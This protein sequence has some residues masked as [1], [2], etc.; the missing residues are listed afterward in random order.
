MIEPRTLSQLLTDDSLEPVQRAIVQTLSALLPDVRVV[1]HP[2]RVD[3]SE[4]LAKSVATAPGIGIG[5]SRVRRAMHVDGSF[6][7]LV[8]WVAYIVTEAKLVSGK[9]VEK[10]AIGLAIGGQVLRVL[11]D[12]E[13]CFWG[14]SGILPPERQPEP[15]LKPLFTVRDAA[16]A[17]AYYTVTWTQIVADIGT[18]LFAEQALGRFDPGTIAV[19][20]PDDPHVA[21]AIAALADQD[22]ADD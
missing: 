18:S 10:E 7:A 6:G 14:R 3:L 9:R 13:K 5:W 17:T 22:D 2:G 8:E 15:D 1:A 21:R 16:N 11:A 19:S 20:Y 4:L 12:G